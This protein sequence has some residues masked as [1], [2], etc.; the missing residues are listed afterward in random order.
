MQILSIG[1]SL[2]ELSNLVS[3]KNKKKYQFV[4]HWVYP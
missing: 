1:D 2:H 3:E 4:I